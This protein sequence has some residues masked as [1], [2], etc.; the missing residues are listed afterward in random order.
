[1][2]DTTLPIRSVGLVRKHTSILGKGGVGFFR[3]FFIPEPAQTAGHLT[4]KYIDS[5]NGAV[6]DIANY[7]DGSVRGGATATLAIYHRGESEKTGTVQS[8]PVTSVS[9]GATISSLRSRQPVR[10]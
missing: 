4:Q 8:T 5:M 7:V 6:A 9:T 3:M 1:M 2:N 10:S